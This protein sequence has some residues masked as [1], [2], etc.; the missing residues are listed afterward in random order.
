[1]RHRNGSTSRQLPA[2]AF[3]AAVAEASI[4]Y[5]IPVDDIV[6]KRR[7]RH[8]VRARQYAMW[9]LIQRGYSLNEI[10]R[11]FGYHHTNVMH[12]EAVVEATLAQ[13]REA[14]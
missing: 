13:K 8:I 2:S 3:A 12:A 5:Q 9:L 14:A 10:A 4:A 11:R 1:M 6:G 7:F